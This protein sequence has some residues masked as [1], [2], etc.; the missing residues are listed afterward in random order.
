MSVNQAEAGTGIQ[1]GSQAEATTGTPSGQ[2]AGNGDWA[3]TV[4]KPAAPEG[5][6]QP[7]PAADGEK[8]S[9]APQPDQDG[10]GML[11][12]KPGEPAKTET[13]KDPGAKEGEEGQGKK[14]GD[15]QGEP[16]DL[17]I[18]DGFQA[19]AKRMEKFKGVAKELKIGKDGAQ[20][21]F[22]M[23][24]A[25]MAES[26]AALHKQTADYIRQERDRIDREGNAAI[27]ADPEVG[28]GNFEASFNYAQK[29]IRHFMPDP[30]EY[31]EVLSLYDQAN[32]KN[33][34]L[35]FK[36]WVRIG[37]YISEAGAM[38]GSPAGKT[39]NSFAKDWYPDLA[40][41]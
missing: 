15:G 26:Q 17:T 23:F 11:P 2:P 36:A 37:K 10:E 7:A 40:K 33:N 31:R 4:N 18:P 41:G 20:K 25:E 12:G 5:Q 1:T 29:A 6:E 22:D 39:E 32:L 13:G 8:A 14:D 16:L 34:P 35:L 28:G 24:H 21:L 38:V 27:H 9:A 19:D 30:K 3:A